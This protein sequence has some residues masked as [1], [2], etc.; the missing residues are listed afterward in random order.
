M[1]NRTIKLRAFYEG[2]MHDAG[3]TTSG[4]ITVFLSQNATPGLNY[5]DAAKVPLMQFTGLT[6]SEGTEIYEDDVVSYETHPG[7]E[8][9][10]RVVWRGNG[11]NIEP[12]YA[13]RDFDELAERDR[14]TVAGNVHENPELLERVQ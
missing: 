11:W 7:G 8:R 12:E 13:G 6:D 2:R 1:T 14:F 4:A 10:A 5:L 3:I 9:L